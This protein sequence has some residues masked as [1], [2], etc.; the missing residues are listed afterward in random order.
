MW[1]ALFFDVL[2]KKP[3]FHVEEITNG[4]NIYRL[5]VPA[6][7][8]AAYAQNLKKQEI[9]I[10]VPSQKG[11]DSLTLVVNESLNRRPA[12]ELAKSFVAAL[13]SS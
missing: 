5:H 6:E 12:E 4:T 1:P 2:G 13:E 8:L 3:G 7:D 9:H 11:V 10:R